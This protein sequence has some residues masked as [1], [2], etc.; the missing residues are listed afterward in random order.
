MKPKD[1][2]SV[3][4]MPDNSRLTAKQYSF[5]LPVHVAAKLAALCE[6]Y[7]SKTRTQIVADLLATAIELASE[8]L[9]STKGRQ[10][11]HVEADDGTLLDIFEDVGLAGR[12]KVL[13]NKHFAELERELGN[14]EPGVAYEY[15]YVLADPQG[16]VEAFT[17]AEEAK[18]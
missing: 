17:I 10:L 9:P 2:H 1:L 3:W 5:R 4:S 11:D 16:R 18:R 12:Y 14:E 8:G 6:L 15:N 7:P 13:A